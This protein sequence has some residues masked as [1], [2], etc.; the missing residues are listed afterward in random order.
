MREKVLLGSFVMAAIGIAHTVLRDLFQ[1]QQE[2]LPIV[3]I[4]VWVTLS[5]SFSWIMVSRLTIR[6]F[7]DL[8]RAPY[9]NCLVFTICI[10]VAAHASMYIQSPA[11]ING[12]FISAL[13]IFS[14]IVHSALEN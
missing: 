1:F 6:D 2:M 10:H 11:L 5:V 12:L 8:Y 9:F 7:D 14:N 3:S 13:A 4:T